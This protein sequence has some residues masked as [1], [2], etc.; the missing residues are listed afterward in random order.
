M[1][2]SAG[3]GR[4]GGGLGL[5][6]FRM[7]LVYVCILL[8]QPQN[9]FT[10]LWPLHIAELSFIAAVGL[11]V[12]ACM[13]ERRPLL[14]FGPGTATGLVLLAMVPLSLA[15]GAFSLGFAWN[16]WVDMFV[17]NALLLI[18]LEAMLTS[19]ERVW[20]TQMTALVA[21]FYWLK[22]GLRLAAAGATYSG[23]RMMGAAIGLLD[24]PNSLA[25]MMC[26]YLP[27]YLYACENSKAKWERWAYLVLLFCAIYVIFKT[28]SRTGLVGLLVL[29]AFMLP[30]Q[31]VHNPKGVVL[32]ALAV[33]LILP[34]SGEKNIQRFKTIPQ[35][36]SAFFT[37]KHSV[38]DRLLTQDEQ[39]AE[40]RRLKNKHTWA[41][42]KRH[43]VFGA[44][45][46]P[47]QLRFPSDLPMAKGQVHCEILAMG[48]RLG[49]PGMLLYVV[50][51]AIAA[52]C[53]WK[54][55]R[56]MRWWPAMGNFG[57]MFFLQTVVLVIGG[58]FCPLA[59]H[60]PMMVLV[61]SA[62]AMAKLCEEDGGGTGWG[63]TGGMRRIAD[64]GGK[65]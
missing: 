31:L 43:P 8:T 10:F 5:W 7:L 21:T 17:K 49:M 57:R 23:D 18:L 42:I 60:P 40:D 62:S 52:V 3:T 58:S 24:N 45:I 35:S 1:T 16:N 27:L 6:A 13:Q 55:M 33:V 9:R 4:R 50:M 59:C 20:A 15:F 56:R 39:S 53:G 48:I 32:T 65:V 19:K 28:G 54:T 26:F 46:N 14:C 41:L 63:G 34:M 38:T 30:R 37:G 47:D 12:L 64:G 2:E 11:H 22:A 29:G 51:W 36:M 44:G 61:A 25:Y